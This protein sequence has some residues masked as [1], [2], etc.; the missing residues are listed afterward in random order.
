[1]YS[2]KK[3]AKKIV[4]QIIYI[5]SSENCN[6]YKVKSQS[7]QW[8]MVNMI[9]HRNGCSNKLHKAFTMQ[10]ALGEG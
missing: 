6:I 2:T 7:L 4:S 3:L 10:T 9:R 1:M 5:M 8:D